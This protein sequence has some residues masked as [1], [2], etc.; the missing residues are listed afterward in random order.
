MNNN[1]NSSRKKLSIFFDTATRSNFDIQC[2]FLVILH[3]CFLRCGCLSPSLLCLFSSTSPVLPSNANRLIV[4][5]SSRVLQRPLKSICLQASNGCD[6]TTL[7]LNFLP[8][9]NCANLLTRP[10]GFYVRHSRDSVS[11]LCDTTTHNNN[12]I[13]AQWRAIAL[14]S[15]HRRL[16]I[17]SHR[18]LSSLTFISIIM[19]GKT[20]N[21]KATIEPTMLF[22]FGFFLSI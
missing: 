18:K 9:N 20:P 19:F 5:N 13:V 11:N 7:W 12:N 22:M 1:K 21:L 2:H 15:H 6:T 10:A 4:S 16:Y 8:S 14:Q 17:C 3:F